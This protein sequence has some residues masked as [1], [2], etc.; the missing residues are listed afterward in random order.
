[1]KDELVDP[2]LPLLDVVSDIYAVYNWWGIVN[3]PSLSE[4]QHEL[5]VCF[6]ASGVIFLITPSMVYFTLG[7]CG[8]FG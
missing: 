2:F 3:I 6:F 8:C 4:T 1:M 5:A 7:I